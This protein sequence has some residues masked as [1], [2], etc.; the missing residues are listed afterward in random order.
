MNKKVKIK[1]DGTEYKVN[2]GENILT[3]CKSIGIDIPAL[4]YSEALKPYGACRLCIVNV[5]SGNNTRPGIN[6]SCTLTASEGMEI[7]TETEEITNHRKI[8]FQFYLAQAPN[9]ET[10]RKLAAKY[11]V[12]ETPFTKKERKE[13]NLG[14]KCVLCGLCVRVCNDIIQQGVINY[15]GRGYYAKI[16]TAFALPSD[17]CLG[18]KACAEVCPTGAINFEDIDD[19]RYAHSWSETKIQL[20]QCS[21]C[22]EYYSPQP[23]NSKTLDIMKPEI[24]K[25]L[26]DMC[27][28]CRRKI[29]SKKQV[30][31]K[32]SRFNILNLK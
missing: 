17:N 18:C 21:I 30:A 22:G 28:S 4:C 15:T 26:K 6:T 25:E 3:F 24:D 10:I 23:F 11:D 29:S 5:I 1:I 9:S 12:M 13:D 19:I 31:I 27:P 2:E 7:E 16:N 14:S 8:L 20:K 32:E